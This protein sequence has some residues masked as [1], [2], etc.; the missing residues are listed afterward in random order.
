MLLRQAIDH[1]RRSS[2]YLL[3][4]ALQANAS[5]LA[6]IDGGHTLQGV[7]K[8]YDEVIDWWQAPGQSSAPAPAYTRRP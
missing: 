3:L 7:C 6:E 4:E 2:L 5:L 1:A 8:A